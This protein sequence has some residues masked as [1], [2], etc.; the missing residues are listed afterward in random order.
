MADSTGPNQVPINDAVNAG[1]DPP[2]PLES[3]LP[4][5]WT[6]QP[7]GCSRRWHYADEEYRC[8]VYTRYTICS[9]ACTC[10]LTTEVARGQATARRLG[11]QSADCDASAALHAWKVHLLFTNRNFDEQQGDDQFSRYL[12][13]I[14]WNSAREWY[15]GF[16]HT[17][18]LI[19]PI[20]PV[21]FVNPD[22]GL[23]AGAVPE[24]ADQDEPQRQTDERIWI[25]EL[26]ELI[27]NEWDRN[28]FLARHR[29]GL[30]AA[31]IAQQAGCA[32]YAVYQSLWG[33][34]AILHARL[35]DQCDG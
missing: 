27:P 15:R 12:A 26:A 23:A 20:L 18:T 30:S 21:S 34:Y 19:G 1:P 7:C 10:V 32:P 29:D 11:Q 6:D 24:P 35:L 9:P 17:D 4:P 33:S 3:P 22:D 31:E 8:F 25:E 2:V 28:V 13:Q 16:Y 5:G 14:A